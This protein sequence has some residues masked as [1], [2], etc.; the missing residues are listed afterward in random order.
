MCSAVISL[1]RLHCFCGPAAC[2]WLAFFFLMI[3]RPPRS[4]LFPYTTLFRSNLGFMYSDVEGIPQD[5]EKALYWYTRA[6]EEGNI[7]AL[8]RVGVINE[9]GRGKDADY[10]KAMECYT[11]CLEGGYPKA[12]YRLGMMYLDGKGVPINADKAS[13]FFVKAADLGSE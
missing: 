13:K 5:W 3:R 2:A 11:K 9:E 10:P 8:Y 7:M 6:A 12:G 1:C 4:T